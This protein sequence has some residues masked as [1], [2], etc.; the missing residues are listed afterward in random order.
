M[1]IQVNDRELIVK[2]LQVFAIHERRTR[3]DLFMA[4]IEFHAYSKAK[5]GICRIPLTS[6]EKEKICESIENVFKERDN[7]GGDSE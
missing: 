1:K 3:S 2:N 7:I 4:E 5:D 6:Y